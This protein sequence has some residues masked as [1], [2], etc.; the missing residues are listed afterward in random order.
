MKE[1]IFKILENNL[2]DE[3]KPFSK[4]EEKY[5]EIKDLS[6][7][8][9]GI[10]SISFLEIYMTVVE[11]AQNNGCCTEDIAPNDIRTIH[12]MEKFLKN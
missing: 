7:D 10:D 5:D 2:L 11:E 12:G 3:Y 8:N 1:K 6:L 4:F 9:I